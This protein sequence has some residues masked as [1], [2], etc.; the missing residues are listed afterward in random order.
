MGVSASSVQVESVTSEHISNHILNLGGS[1]E[2]A[3]R[4]LNDNICGQTLREEHAAGR[5]QEF[6]LSNC[7]VQQDAQD[8]LCEAL[9]QLIAGC[10]PHVYLEL[11]DEEYHCVDCKAHVTTHAR[12]ERERDLISRIVP[13][14]LEQPHGK[15]SQQRGVT[16]AWLIQFTNEHNCWD[17]PTWQVRRE[18]VLPVT[19]SS[20][21]RFVELPR[22]M[23]GDQDYGVVGAAKTF[24]S[25]AWGAKWGDLVAAVSETTERVWIDIFAVRQWPSNNPH[26]ELDF[27][28]TIQECSSFLLVCSELQDVLHMDA[29]DWI[30]RNTH[31]LSEATR[32]QIPFLRV[33]CLAEINAA[34]TCPLP[35]VMKAGSRR[36]GPDGNGYFK[37]S[38]K[39][40]ANLAV[41]IDIRNAEAT[42][43]S[44]KT[45]ILEQVESSGGG[46]AALNA[47]VRGA[48][49]GVTNSRVQAAAC[50]D[51]RAL[52]D[53]LSDPSSSLCAAAGGGFTQLV[54]VLLDRGADVAAVDRDPYRDGVTALMHAAAGGHEQCVQMLLERGADVAAVASDDFTALIFAAKCGHGQCVQMLLDCGADVAAVTRDGNTALIFAAVGGHGRCLEILLNGRADVAAV[55]RSG[56]TAL[57]YAALGGHDKCLEILLASGADVAAVSKNGMTALMFAAVGKHEKCLEILLASGADV[58]AMLL[59]R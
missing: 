9:N 27:A 43:P 52:E 35:I 36:V 48:L 11:W 53:M 38:D 13:D 44:D 57:M 58:A 14:S 17:M 23:P 56:T 8:V 10:C 3:E 28:S 25:H 19:A 20:R 26:G 18:F 1:E 30:S 40:L 55:N 12:L 39:M 33:W 59:R 7:G 41:M 2:C 50:G 42:K 31:K 5:I 46:V 47:A 54:G 45:N 4:F 32:Q 49:Y 6:L 22:F 15:L 24:V 51:P 21:C 16:I 29:F 34:V 37:K